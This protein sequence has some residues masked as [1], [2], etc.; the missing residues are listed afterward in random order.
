M[1]KLLATPLWS[2]I[3]KYKP[4]ARNRK[5][6]YKKEITQLTFQWKLIVKHILKTTQIVNFVFISG[7]GRMW[8]TPTVSV[9]P[10]IIQYSTIQFIIAILHPTGMY[11][12]MNTFLL[13]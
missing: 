6:I 10:Y 2:L 4:W 7:E 8:Y 1:L 3:D 11:V 5:L 13:F 12:L 9:H